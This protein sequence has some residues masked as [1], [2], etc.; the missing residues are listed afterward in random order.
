MTAVSSWARE[1]F[2]AVAADLQVAVPAAIAQAHELAYAAHVASE[3]RTND[4]YGSTLK[5]TQYEQLEQHT[6]GL[7]GVVARKPQELTSRFA[8]VVAEET[9]TVLFPWRFATDSA[10]S[11]VQAR[12]RRPLSEL[13]KTLLGLTEGGGDVQLVL[14]QGER[15]PAELEAEL[16]EERELLAELAAFGRVVTVGFSCNPVGGIFE[17]GWGDAELLDPETG[18]VHWHHW[19]ALSRQV[20]AAAGRELVAVPEPAPAAEATPRFDD[21]P[22]DELGLTARPPLTQPDSGQEQTSQPGTGSDGLQ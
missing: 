1:R 20:G 12:M 22:L 11:R 13:R 4:A 9:A 15:D 7:P 8:L 16:A 3:L 2:G 5:V 17:L 14:E 6:A 21:A 10:T 19:E 18:Q